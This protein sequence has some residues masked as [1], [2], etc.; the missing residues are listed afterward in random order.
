M[1]TFM[2]WHRVYLR[3]C[4]RRKPSSAAPFVWYIVLDHPSVSMRISKWNEWCTSSYHPLYASCHTHPAFSVNSD[5][6]QPSSVSIFFRRVWIWLHVNVSLFWF[7]TPHN[8]LFP[9]RR[10]LNH[11]SLA[12]I[13]GEW[14][15]RC[16]PGERRIW[17]NKERG[18]RTQTWGTLHFRKHLQD[19]SLQVSLSTQLTRN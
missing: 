15:Q 3:A 9:F 11:P 16:A 6:L 5:V 18:L 17:P 19:D 13:R 12:F 8:S 14:S 4:A 7:S 2:S 1:A 10:A